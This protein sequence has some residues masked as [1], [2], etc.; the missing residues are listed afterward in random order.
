MLTP[1][2]LLT[3]LKVQIVQKLIPK[4]QSDDYVEEVAEAEA[5]ATAER[6]AQ[7]PR[8]PAVPYPDP[9]HPQL[10]QPNRGLLPDLAR[11]RPA[12]VGDFP[13]PG[14]EDEHQMFS[15][16]AGARL[17]QPLAQPPFN[18]GHDDLHPPGL[19][20][21]DPLRGS[22]T[23]DGHLRGP[24]HSGMHPTFDDPLFRGQGS[25]MPGRG[26]YDPQVPPGARWDPLGPGGNPRFPGPDGGGGF[27]GFGPGGGGGII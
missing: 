4:L 12:P 20:P 7:Q 1:L 10:L 2:A 11:P 19:G 9:D 17:P 21:H 23:P 5:T 14:F 26:G 6:R 15:S 25:G 16:P 13:A 27:G 22:F 24:G 8:Q 18:I 3:D